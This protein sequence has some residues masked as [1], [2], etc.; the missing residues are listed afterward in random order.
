M[1]GLGI[2]LQT[3]PAV[4]GRRA[5]IVTEEVQGLSGRKHFLTRSEDLAAK[6]RKGRHCDSNQ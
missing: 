3:D 6:L 1:R 4:G 5:L 2:P